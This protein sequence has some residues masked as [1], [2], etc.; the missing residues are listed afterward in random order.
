[1]DDRKK[2]EVSFCFFFLSISKS[3][4]VMTISLLNYPHLF[5]VHVPSMAQK[6]FCYELSQKT[7]FKALLQ[8]SELLLQKKK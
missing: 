8:A 6:S 1:M 2:S 5:N 3:S 7:K 4:H